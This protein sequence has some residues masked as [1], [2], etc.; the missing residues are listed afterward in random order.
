MIL[1]HFGCSGDPDSP[2]TLATPDGY[3]ASPLASDVVLENMYE[4]EVRQ[5]AD[6]TPVHIVTVIDGTSRVTVDAR[7][8]GIRDMGL[9]FPVYECELTDAASEAMGGIAQGMSGSPVGPPGRVMG[10]LAYGDAF[11]GSPTRFWVTPIDAMEQAKSLQTFGERLDA[12]H[13][14]AAPSHGTMYAPVKTPLMLT[15]IQPDQL[16]RLASYLKGANY[17][18]LQLLSAVGSAPQANAE[19]TTHLTAGSMIGAAVVRGDVINAIG[20]GTVTQV[21][22][23]GSFLA[24]G[25]PMMSSGQSALS[26]YNAV[27]YGI[28]PSL[29]TSYKS[30][31]AYGKPIGTITKDLTPA[32]VGVT[33]SVPDMIPVKLVYQAGTEAPIEKYHEVAYGQETFIP[34]V[35]AYTLNALQQEIS[36]GTIDTTITLRFLETETPYTDS[37]RMTS[38]DI[39]FDTLIKVDGILSEFTTLMNG[40]GKATLTNV[41]IFIKDTPQYLTATID[42]VTVSEDT[43]ITGITETIT[44]VL[45]PHWSAAT[46]GRRLQEEVNIDIPKDFP[47]GEAILELTASGSADPFFD[48]YDFFGDEPSTPEPDTLDKLIKQLQEKQSDP[49]TITITIQ[50]TP[51]DWDNFDWEN[52]PLPDE[53]A[54][55]AMIE[56][57]IVI[58]GFIVTGTKQKT[59]EIAE[60]ILPQILNTE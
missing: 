7:F 49:G 1:S 27:C 15:G 39:L 35:T 40:A 24:F 26:V 53:D 45:L 33:R 30:V 2:T 59:V 36:P 19:L 23:D 10:A 46:N 52:D 11:S 17:Q 14:P 48:N 4:S 50:P 47:I 5:L 58:E 8:R 16:G 18:Y 31:T 37:F 54:E 57:T 41:D 22:E 28:V 32:I 29:Q 51:F 9:G 56:K 25:H 13:A 34:V 21:Y 6:K 38:T 60:H 44:I 3:T 55:T 20:Y 43:L 42:E 12:L